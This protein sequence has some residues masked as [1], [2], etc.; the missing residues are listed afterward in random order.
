MNSRQIRVGLG[1]TVADSGFELG[2]TFTQQ[3][4]NATGDYVGS[5]ASAVGNLTIS[6]AGLGYTP[7]DGSFTFSGV[8]LVTIT[9]NGRGCLLYTS[10]SPRDRQKSRMPSS[11]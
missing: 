2:N 6:N 10:P 5:A 9:G 4:T 8:N 1:T 11:A 3:G 7:A